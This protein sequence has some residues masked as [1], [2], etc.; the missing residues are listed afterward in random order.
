MVHS[1]ALSH[2]RLLKRFLLTTPLLLWACNTD[3]KSTAAP[4]GTEPLVFLASVAPTP[5]GARACQPGEVAA[6]GVRWQ[7]ATGTMAGGFALYT[8]GSER[9][10]V[11]GRV[12]VKLLNRAGATIPVLIE[13]F[14]VPAP[15]AVLLL[16]GLGQPASDEG[17]T[18]GRAYVETFWSNWCGPTELGKGR[19]EITIEGVGQIVA[20]VPDLHPPRC[21]AKAA[22]SS[23]SVSPI[24]APEVETE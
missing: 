21:D 20:D 4:T 1:R 2:G 14:D 10:T 13:A 23:F 7:G 5:Q 15:S 18:D 9:C 16:P 19:I 6:G 24:L 17:V 11:G 8:V 3:L 22:P 12:H